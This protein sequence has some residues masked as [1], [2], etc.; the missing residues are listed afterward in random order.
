[1]INK[2]VRE[3][4]SK[5]I[6]TW[7]ALTIRIDEGEDGSDTT[8]MPNRCNNL[9]KFVF[10]VRSISLVNDD[11]ND[12]DIKEDQ[13][14]CRSNFYWFESFNDAHIE[15]LDASV[16]RLNGFEE[17]NRS[18]FSS[19]VLIV[20]VPKIEGVDPSCGRWIGENE[21]LLSIDSVCRRENQIKRVELIRRLKQLGLPLEAPER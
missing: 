10:V 18:G 15:N 11:D 20:A 17:S 19:D 13:G 8:S 6:R 12:D 5:R 2:A 1:M 21:N 16:I 4:L 14:K 7:V 9:Q 3:N